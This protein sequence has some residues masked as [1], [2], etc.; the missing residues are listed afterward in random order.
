MLYLASTSPRRARLL[1]EAGIAF[2]PLPPGPEPEG[3]GGPVQRAGQ[4]ARAKAVGAPPPR[5]G[6]PVLGVDTVVD[7]DGVELGKPRDR[8][9]AARMLELLQ[10]RQH[11]V[12]TG[13]CL[14]VGG[15]VRAEQ[16]AT[17]VVRVATLAPQQREAY[18]DSGA[19]TGLAGGYGIQ[20]EAGAFVTLVEG[21]FDTVVGLSV[22]AVRR[23]LRAASEGRP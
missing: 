22:V 20:A 23:L 3:S 4:R 7:C 5:D 17:S 13:H 14:A 11:R 21:D 10:G 6:S 8:A 19:W 15:V 12:H 9:D 16:L 1:T 2:A 18:L